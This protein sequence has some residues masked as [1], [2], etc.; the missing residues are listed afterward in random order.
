MK[1]LWTPSP[2]Q[3]KEKKKKRVKEK[4]KK[5]PPLKRNYLTFPLRST[6]DLSLILGW[7]Y[8]VLLFAGT[9]ASNCYV[10]LRGL[11]RYQHGPLTLVGV[12]VNNVVIV[13][14]MTRRLDACDRSC[15]VFR[16]ASQVALPWRT[17]LTA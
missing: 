2:Y 16:R 5:N 14:G 17:P 3:H 8:D 15:Q 12:P 1:A 11:L 7:R 4:E 6:P 9:G 13:I 10:N